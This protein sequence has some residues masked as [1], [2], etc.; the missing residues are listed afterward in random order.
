M[1]KNYLAIDIGGTRIKYALINNSGT[2]TEKFSQRTVKSNLDAFLKQLNDIIG[3]YSADIRG[4]G[5]SVPGKV[6]HPVDTII[7]GGALTFLDGVN[8][9]TKL[10]LDIPVT[11]ENDGK[12]AALAELWLGNFKN[13][14]DGMMVVLGTGVGGGLI[15]NGKLVYGKHYQAGE[16]SFLFTKFK[17]GTQTSIGK[18]CSAVEMIKEIGIK[19][20][21]KDIDDGMTVF[22]HINN[23]DPVA[24][25]IFDK[26]AMEIALLIQNIQAMVDVQRIVIGG[27]ISAQDITVK[28]INEKYM[29][30]FNETAMVKDTLTPVE[31][32][33]AKFYNDANLYGAIYHLLMTMNEEI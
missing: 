28:R 21:L 18:T 31:I 3:K 9:R 16:L 4:V 26:Y 15:L 13:I 5:I 23:N 33:P 19:L 14:D 8:L 30:F 17:D 32:M 25:E 7:G 24:I 20:G 2:I 22:E 12:A 11:L 10:N 29:E 27:G 1:K 6:E